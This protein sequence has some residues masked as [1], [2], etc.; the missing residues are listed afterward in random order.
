MEANLTFKPLLPSYPQLINCYTTILYYLLEKCNS[1]LFP[2]FRDVLTSNDFSINPS[3]TDNS[4]YNLSSEAATTE[5][6]ALALERLSNVAEPGLWVFRVDTAT[7]LS[8]G[9]YT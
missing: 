9:T 2:L 3:L 7:I 5:E 8:G 6:R 4:A 1:K